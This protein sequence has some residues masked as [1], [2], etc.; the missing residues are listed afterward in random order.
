MLL[1]KI[2]IMI[3]FFGLGFIVE[4]VVLILIFKYWEYNVLVFYLVWGFVLVVS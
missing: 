3:V 1:L 4:D 2:L